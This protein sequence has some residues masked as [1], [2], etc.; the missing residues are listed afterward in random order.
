[1]IPFSYHS[2]LE[3]GYKTMCHVLQL[4]HIARSLAVREIVAQAVVGMCNLLVNY[5]FQ[6][7]ALTPF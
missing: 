6:M 7:S 1:M 2:L 4:A 5:C 3:S